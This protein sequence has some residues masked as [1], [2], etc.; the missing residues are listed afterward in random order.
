MA[1]TLDKKMPKRG[2]GGPG[3]RFGGMGMTQTRD[4][5][6]KA[7]GLTPDKLEIAL[8][9]GK[10]LAEVAKD[11]KV[12]VESLVKA[13]VTATKGEL[14]AAVKNGTMTQARADRMEISLTQRITDRVNR[15]R[16][17]RGM[18]H[19]PRGADRSSSAGGTSGGMGT[20]MSAPST[21]S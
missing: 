8:R 10:S 18:G 6:A 5:A 12:S 7:L 11:Q 19:G 13:M 9:S 16:P 20:P 1:S 14:A 2:V 21:M 15:V 3:A 17:D 4:A